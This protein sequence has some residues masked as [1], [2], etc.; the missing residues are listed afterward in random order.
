M[1]AFLD[2]ETTHLKPTQGSIIEVA[3]IITDDS[4][5]RLASYNQI[6]RPLFQ[7][8]LWN[9]VEQRWDSNWEDEVIRRMHADSG[10]AAEIEDAPRRYEVELDAIDW[11]PAIPDGEP[12]ILVGNSIEFDANW[13][14]EHMPLLFQRFHRQLL[15]VTSLNQ[16]A[17]LFAPK[18]YE[19][20][21][22]ADPKLQHRALYDAQQSLKTLVYYRDSF[23]ISPKQ[24]VQN[25]LGFGKLYPLT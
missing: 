12:L 15:N 8:M 5:N 16:F 11:L 4:L 6:V 22:K 25:T 3:Y 19:G 14:R 18:V 17:R 24:L 1:L 10:L 20:R 23:C 21:P 13:L 7:D 2:L 9:E